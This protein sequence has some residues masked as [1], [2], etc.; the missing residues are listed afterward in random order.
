MS[1]NTMNTRTQ[2]T[3]NTHP[4]LSVDSPCP[5]CVP[6]APPVCHH[7]MLRDLN[8]GL[9]PICHAAIIAYGLPPAMMLAKIEDEKRAR[10]AE[11]CKSSLAKFF[12]D[13]WSVI[14]SS[15]DLEDSWHF[16]VLALHLETMF[17]QWQARKRK[18]KGAKFPLA[19]DYHLQNLLV[20][21]PPGTAKS[22]FIM[23][24]F[25]A[26]VW[27]HDPSF[28]FIALSGN[29]EVAKRDA[30]YT[31]SLVESPWYR[32]TF[33]PQWRLRVDR[34]AIG[35]Y[36]LEGNDGKR[37]GSRFS[38]GIL[39]TIVGQRGDGILFDDPH[40]P[41]SVEKG[42]NDA[43]L[44]VINTWEKS[45]YNRVNNMTRSLRVIVMQRVHKNDMSAHVLSK[46]EQE[47][48]HLNMPLTRKADYQTNVTGWIDP[49]KEGERLVPDMFTDKVVAAEKAR[50]FDLYSSMYEQD[51]PDFGGALYKS[52]DFRWFRFS[53]YIGP[54]N[55]PP[56]SN[57]D[58]AWVIDED[59][60]T[61]FSHIIISIDA[62]NQEN[63]KTA[64]LAQGSE[65]G[66]TVWGIKKFDRFMLE[67]ATAMV[68][69]HEVI[70]IVKDILARY[71][72]CHKAIVENKALGVAVVSEL[73]RHI[74]EVVAIEPQGSKVARARA[75]GPQIAT[76]R[77]WIQE[78]QRW[79]EP[80][81]RQVYTFPMTPDGRNDRL[82][83]MT[84]L[85]NYERHEDH[86][87]RL[88]KLANAPLPFYR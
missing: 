69:I 23:V 17:A 36:E 28:S 20:N 86:T 1:L 33:L 83:T 44:R 49:R 65:I 37:L 22:R 29:P 87:E 57:D 39:S 5:L 56:G 14:E 55:R 73:R 8:D 74:S 4:L 11:A 15:T 19:T 21:M 80:F 26:W 43:L 58:P 27:L 48:H 63:A 9:C 64:A 12:R 88:R 47:W 13:A 45:F 41:R 30:E 18:K 59:R 38:T 50:L 31:R 3:C 84:Q 35:F 40:D 32:D 85:L 10:R 78:G 71:P 25:P 54:A 67:D 68:G 70:G 62:N 2:S 6:Q 76:G 61:W 51:P 34:N 82:D 79:N 75:A 66:I 77:V 72:R 42:D 7:E 53:D 46:A 16:D 52:T 24:C 60:H 81:C